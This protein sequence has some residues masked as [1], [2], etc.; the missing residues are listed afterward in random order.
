MRGLNP[1]LKKESWT[2]EEDGLL[3]HGMGKYGNCWRKISAEIP[4]RCDVQCRYRWQQ[5]KRLEPELETRQGSPAPLAPFPS[6]NTDFTLVSPQSS[7][8]DAWYRGQLSA[9]NSGLGFG[10]VSSFP[11]APEVRP[12]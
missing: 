2:A 6:I 9:F 11:S 12:A 8:T 5:M 3:L 10:G 1:Q 4:G 7:A